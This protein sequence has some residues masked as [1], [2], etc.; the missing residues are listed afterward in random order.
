MQVAVIGGGVIGVC[1]AYFLAEAGHEV[2]VIERLG[3][4]AEGASF[5]NAGIIAQS[6]VSPWAAPGMPRKLLA[7]VL[8]SGS[9]VLLRRNMDTA[10]WRWLRMWVSECRLDRYQINKA[11]M[12]RIATYSWD[13]LTQLREQ[14]QIDYEQT[15]GY[16]QLFRTERDLQLAEPAI[17]LLTK[18]NVRHQM[19]DPDA[20]RLIEPGINHDMRFVGGISLPDD[21]AGNCPL[22]TKQL[23]A[24]A[25]SIGVTFRFGSAVQSIQDN[26]NHVSLHIDGAVFD[27]DATVVAA[28]VDSATLLAPLGI[29]IPLYPVKGYS[30]TANIKNYD[31]APLAAMMDEAYQV[32]ISRMG[33]RIRVSGITELGARTMDVRDN[34][35]RTLIKVGE[36]WFPD[37]A[38]FH[39]ANFWCG[40]R[41]MLPDGAPLLGATPI[42]GVYLNIG[43]GSAGWAMAAGSGKV[44]AALVSGRTPDI[45]M[46]GLTLSRYR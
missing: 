18:N 43:H 41:P 6:N 34:A 31:A 10:L 4:V 25:Q 14:H 23:R 17:T 39:T 8:Q 24:I 16:L 26:N 35:L 5:G 11:R 42:K 46:D 40:V 38:N 32:S 27:V 7:S 33:N 28:G 20:I 1:T 13:L 44:L 30:A 22:F 15:R 45:D 36:D 3:N 21:E 2:V 29:R 19:L 9:S 37:A 12:Q